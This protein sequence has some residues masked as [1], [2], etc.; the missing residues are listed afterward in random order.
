M[1]YKYDD[2]WFVWYRVRLCLYVELLVLGIY[3]GKR[4]FIERWLWWMVC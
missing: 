3:F 2:M 4:C 1:L